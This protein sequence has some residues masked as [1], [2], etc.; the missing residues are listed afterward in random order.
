MVR[1]RA[2]GALGSV[3]SALAFVFATLLLFVPIGDC[4]SVTSPSK[5]GGSIYDLGP[6]VRW[7]GACRNE[8]DIR[9]TFIVVLFVVFAVALIFAIT[10]YGLA[11]RLMENPV[12]AD[13]SSQISYQATSQDNVQ[14]YKRCQYCAEQIQAA[15][16]FCK[17]CRRDQVF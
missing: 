9:T 7:A 10:R 11:N 15:A 5:W 12:A 6:R 3:T 8:L 14:K 17:H 2:L 1:H 4:G 16:V 13:S